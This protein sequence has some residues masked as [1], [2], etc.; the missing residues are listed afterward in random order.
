GLQGAFYHPASDSPETRAVLAGLSR[1]Y[2]SWTHD[3]LYQYLKSTGMDLHGKAPS[4]KGGGSMYFLLGDGPE[5]VGDDSRGQ[6]LDTGSPM[7]NN[8]FHVLKSPSAD[9][10]RAVAEAS[11]GK[12][13]A[14]H[15]WLIT[16]D[17]ILV[18]RIQR[19]LP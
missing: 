2:D 9:Y 14:W 7:G 10:A 17:P 18:A 3:D 5:Q 6:M 15:R 12:S 11:G 19:L 16:G 13:V 1:N 8:V 4:N